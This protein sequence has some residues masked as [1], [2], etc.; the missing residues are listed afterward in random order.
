VSIVSNYDRRKKRNIRSLI[1]EP[2]TMLP[3]IYE[4]FGKGKNFILSSATPPLPEELGNDGWNTETISVPSTF[5]AKNRPIYIDFTGKMGVKYRGRTIP[6]IAA[7]ID[8]LANYKTMVHCHSYSIASEISRYLHKDYILQ[9][10]RADDLAK[11]KEGNT[12]IFLSVDMMDGVSLDDDACRI[13]ILA[14]TPFPYFGDKRVKKRIE[15]YGHEWA[16]IQTARKI[17]QAYGRSTRSKDDWSEFHILDSDFGW[18]YQR[19]KRFFPEWFKDAI[20]WR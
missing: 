13:N 16:N 18:F 3:F 7:K 1:F 20:V 8:S 14:K 15:L 2:I 5:P 12:K 6:K 19:N 10:N 17:M 11:F 9:S 4:V